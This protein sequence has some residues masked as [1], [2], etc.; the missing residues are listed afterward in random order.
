MRHSRRRVE[1]DDRS[2]RAAGRV[3]DAAHHQR[4]ALELELRT[5]TEVVGLEA[6]GDFEVSKVGRVDLVERGVAGMADVAAVRRPLTGR[7][8]GSRWR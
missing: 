4:C 2:A 1:R 7:S 6:P 3:G 5:R 8:G